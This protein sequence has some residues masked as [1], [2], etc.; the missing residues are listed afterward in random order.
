MKSKIFYAIAL[1]ALFLTSCTKDQISIEDPPTLD[2]QTEEIQSQIGDQESQEDYQIDMSDDVAYINFNPNSRA[3]PTNATLSYSFSSSVSGTIYIGSSGG[4]W[5]SLGSFSGSSVVVGIP[6]TSAYQQC[7]GMY[8]FNCD[9][10]GSY[11][12]VDGTMRFFRNDGCLVDTDTY[13]FGKYGNYNRHRV[14]IG[15]YS[16]PC[17]NESGILHKDCSNIGFGGCVGRG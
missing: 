12:C 17:P 7:S 6:S 8:E 10:N 9:L 16:G 13:E 5:T 2:Q 14:F 3:N 1:F 11:G 4:G 15:S